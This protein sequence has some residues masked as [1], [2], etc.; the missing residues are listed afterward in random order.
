MPQQLVTRR[1]AAG[2][3]DQFELV[4]IEEHQCMTP[5]LPRQVVQRLLQA[6][7]ELATIGQAGQGVMG[8]LPGQIGNVLTLLGHVV[9]H[10]HSAADLAGITDR[11]AHQVDRY[12]AAV[13]ALNQFGML[14]ATTEL[15]AQNAFDQVKPSAWAFS[16]SRLNNA[17]SGNPVACSAF[18]WVNASAAGF[19]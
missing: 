16:S 10:Q 13:Q 6:I 18:Q 7:L 1:M 12:R 11:R 17:A 9:Q 14:A 2:I 3:V 4:Q 19:M 5:R 8:G 15:T